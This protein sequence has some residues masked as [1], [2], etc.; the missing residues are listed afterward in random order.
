M[1]TIKYYRAAVLVFSLLSFV[2]GLQAQTN[3]LRDIQYGTRHDRQKLDIYLPDSNSSRSLPCFI[4]IHGGGWSRGDKA[5]V[6]QLPLKEII[7]AGYAVA[8]MNYEL[9]SRT[10]K[11]WP[12]NLE[13]CRQAVN[14][15]RE[16]A[17]EYGLDPNRFILSGASAGGHLALMAAYT[18]QDT[19]ISGVQPDP[20][21]AG[22]IRG[23]VA[24]FP[25]CDL[26][27]FMKGFPSAHWGDPIMPESY[28]ANPELYRQGSPAEHV[29]KGNP[30]TLFVYGT[31]DTTVEGDLHSG[32][33]AK[34]LNEAGAVAEQL[35]V[36]GAG[37][38]FIWG[39]STGDV[40]DKMLK[41]MAN[42]LDK[43][44]EEK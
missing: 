23:V 12:R 21:D 20:G 19:S 27:L 16:H 38:S 28:A 40:T 26:T 25:V 4:F 7:Q 30:P 44:H 15:L 11:C 10:N 42:C 13:D 5:M 18:W 6:Q 34:R 1:V 39:T 41:F 22:F 37:H 33:L 31:D 43:H 24:L 36:S 17:E 8:S 14:Y 3:V 9:T 32:A 29:C 35:P 2:S